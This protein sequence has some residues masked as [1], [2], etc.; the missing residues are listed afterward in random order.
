MAN[1]TQHMASQLEQLASRANGAGNTLIV[2]PVTSPWYPALAQLKTVDSVLGS[3]QIYGDIASAVAACVSDR[4]DTIIVTPGAYAPAAEI[5]VSKNDVTIVGLG[6]SPEATKVT[7]PAI[8]GKCAIKVTADNVTVQNLYLVGN[9]ADGYGFGS[10][11]VYTSLINCRFG[12]DNGTAPTQTAGAIFDA[13][14][15]AVPLAPRIKGCRFTTCGTGLT[16]NSGNGATKVLSGAVIEDCVFGNNTVGGDIVSSGTTASSGVNISRCTF[17]GNSANKLIAI[18]SPALGGLVSSCCFNVADNTK[19][20]LTG[21]GA[22][23]ATQGFVNNYTLVGLSTAK[24]G[25]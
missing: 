16:L 21:G 14:A 7:G 17:M 5:V 2:C 8:A 9:V 10:T 3:S 22:L 18:T 25:P 6:G 24:P 4:G 12:S 23:G 19:A 20:L 11:G 15:A 13:S 1:T